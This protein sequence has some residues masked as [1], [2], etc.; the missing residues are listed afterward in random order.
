MR[1]EYEDDPKKPAPV[2]SRRKGE[3]QLEAEEHTPWKV[4]PHG[5]KDDHRDYHRHVRC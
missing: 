3:N 2:R 1:Y 5:Y 4:G